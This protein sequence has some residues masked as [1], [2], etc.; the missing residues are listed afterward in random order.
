MITK[1]LR[2]LFF[3][4]LTA[5]MAFAQTP[6]PTCASAGEYA[7][8][9]QVDPPFLAIRVI[10]GRV[11]VEVNDPA[12]EVGPVNG[13]CLSLFTEK[14]HKLLTS[15]AA[16]EEGRFIFDT[17]K[18]GS[19]R[20]VVHDPQNAFHVANAR[21]RVYPRGQGPVPK[22]IGLVVHLRPAGID[23]CSSISRE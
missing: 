16:N 14:E 19:Y 2:I 12:K 22:S 11:L 21:I 17:V 6:P 9:N 20:L 8:C 7:D 10:T 15:V 1:L 18:P 3:S 5:S 4:L 13:T 23:G